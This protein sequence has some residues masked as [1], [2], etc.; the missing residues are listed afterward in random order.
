MDFHDHAPIFI[1][2]FTSEFPP[3]WPPR[4]EVKHWHDAFRL[5]DESFGAVTGSQRM[6][7]G[8]HPAQELKHYGQTTDETTKTQGFIHL[9][10]TLHN[11]VT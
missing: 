3:F 6:P 10:L 8:W 2:Q 5:L 4:A 11:Y 7:G 9:I 1:G